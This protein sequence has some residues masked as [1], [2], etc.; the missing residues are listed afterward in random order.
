MLVVELGLSIA[1]RSN[2]H[3]LVGT[4]ENSVEE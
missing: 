4:V 2:G 3:H 1:A